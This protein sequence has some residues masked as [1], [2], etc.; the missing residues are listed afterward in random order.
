MLFRG[1]E[2]GID[3]AHRGIVE[4]RTVHKLHCTAMIS[5]AMLLEPRNCKIDLV[6]AIDG[7]DSSTSLI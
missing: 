6:R 2:I 1:E 3:Q 7:V 5:I 4:M